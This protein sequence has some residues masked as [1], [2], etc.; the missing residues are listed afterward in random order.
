M[1]THTHDPA[2]PSTIARPPR[3]RAPGTTALLLGVLLGTG[4]A[5]AQ[6]PASGPLG[7]PGATTTAP[8]PAPA[9]SGPNVLVLQTST[10][11]MAG[12][13]TA[14]DGQNTVTILDET[15]T[16]VRL[17]AARV[18]A[19]IACDPAARPELGAGAFAPVSERRAPDAVLLNR[20]LLARN[21]GFLVTVTG[22][23]Y[24]GGPDFSGAEAG[25]DADRITWLS[26]HLGAF[27]ATLD[28]ISV[29]RFP[30]TLDATDPSGVSA[31]AQLAPP[32]AI[33]QP[34]IPA[35][36]TEDAVVLE[37]ADV[38]RGLIARLAPTVDL[39]AENGGE[40]RRFD[41]ARVA[42][43]VLANPTRPISGPAL[44]LADGSVFSLTR[45]GT[46]RNPRTGA[47]AL[48]VETASGGRGAVAL[49]EVRAWV[50][51]AERLRPL[52]ALAARSPRALPGRV[53]APPAALIAH[54]D[55]LATPGVWA[56]GAQDIVL[57]GGVETTFELPPGATHLLGTAALE[58]DTLEW[59]DCEVVIASSPG[60]EPVRLRLSADAPAAP[61]SVRL[62][63][64]TL[65]V[66]VEAGRYGTVKDKL[67]LMR[68]LVVVNK[69]E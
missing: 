68:P 26:P 7:A 40:P 36:G 48:R 59:G 33:T 41:R 28:H 47:A 57:L 14:I 38:F 39:E 29:V 64:P 16:P 24:L 23:R 21:G 45:T 56:L 20:A 69:A 34:P 43:V 10:K 50:P 58:E 17:E 61:L 15:G 65:T 49:N 37:N 66:R 51:A 31:P 3:V 5:R 62:A 1:N 46:E 54:P 22:E 4:I 18:L 8:A 27:T 25:A 9:P 2:P 11:V 35:P 13:L 53:Y 19:V 42:A 12:R 44:W 63:G 52:S 32:Q 60:V 6:A 30:P 55:D 67:R